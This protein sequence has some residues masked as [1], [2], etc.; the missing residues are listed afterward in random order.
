LTHLFLIRHSRSTWN[1]AGR[2]QGW[3]DP[4]LDDLGREQARQLA[5]R[6][7]QQRVVAL[8][9]SPLQRAQD[10]AHIIGQALNVPVVSDERLKELDVGEIAGLTWEQVVEQYPDVARGWEAASES[11]EFPGQEGSAPFQARVVAAFDDI[12]SQHEHK[13]VGVV[14]HGGVLGTYLN[15]LIRLPSR[16]SPFRFANGS[17]SIVEVNPVRPRILLLNDTCHLGGET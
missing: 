17:L 15:H 4:P 2:I 11:L 5:Q 10:T 1:A 8:Y 16:F 13:T 7:R 9:T 14:T 12:V 6:L 3:A